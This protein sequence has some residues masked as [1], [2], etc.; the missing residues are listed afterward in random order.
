[1]PAG[2]ALPALRHGRRPATAP[3][4][5]CRACENSPL[6]DRCGHPRGD[7]AEVFVR[8]DDPGCRR[9]VGDFQ[10]LSS[11]LCSCPGFRPVAGSLR[12]AAFAE[13]DDDPKPLRLA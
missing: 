8:G 13:P 6:C 12:E 4:A 5:V 10:T 9:L 7:H 11:W 1:M 2:D 3:L